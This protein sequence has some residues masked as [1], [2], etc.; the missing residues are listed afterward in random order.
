LKSIIIIPLLLTGIISA[1]GQVRFK[2]ISFDDALLQSKKKGKIIFLQYES[3]NCNQCN[4]VADKAFANEDLAELINQTFLCIKITPSHPDRVRIASL[5]NKTDDSFGSMFISSDGNLVHN[6]S[7]SATFI[8]KYKEEI[9]QALT[10]AGEGIKANQLE[11]E[12]RSGNKSPGLMELLMQIKK[13]LSLETDSL[14][15]DYVL[16]QPADSFKSIRTLTF[17]AQMAPVLESKASMILRADNNLFDKA[18]QSLELSERRR[19]NNRIVNKSMQKA[20][21]EKNKAFAYKVADFRRRTYGNNA[22][23]GQMAY[24]HE[25]IGYYFETKDTLSYLKHAVSYYDNYYMTV[26]ID[27]VKSKDSLEMKMMF[28]KQIPAVS[29]GNG[30]FR[31]IIKYAPV[32][33]SYN[34]ELDNAARSFYL[35][36]NEPIYISEALSWAARANEFFEK[37]TSLNTFAL[38]LYKSGRKEEAI[39]WQNKAISLKKKMGF[40][41]TSLEKELAEMKDDKTISIN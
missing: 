24:S 11:K 22:R 26:S 35:M 9:D 34:I 29:S 16:V 23:A 20:I 13:S 33:Q 27:S 36:T 28:A 25:M 7:G 39:I 15:E 6:Y 38:L 10:K 3:A 14:L 37:Y 19:I 32:S 12:Y 21:R 41:A 30:T 18:W 5:Y 17:I 31:T 8:N 40:D 2:S 1:F 4:E